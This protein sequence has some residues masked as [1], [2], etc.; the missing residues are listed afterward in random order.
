MILSKTPLRISLVGGSSDLQA[1]LD[2]Y[3]RGSVISF[4]SSLYTYITLKERKGTYK[5]TYSHTEEVVN[6]KD[7]KNDIAREVIQQFDLPPCEIGFNCD[8]PSTGSGLASSSSYL[9]S[10]LHAASFYWK[11]KLTQFDL[12][13]MALQIERKFNPLTGHQDPYGCGLGSLKRLNFYKNGDVE[14]KYL[15]ES[16]LNGMYMYL[17]PTN[18]SRSSTDVL[19]TIDIDKCV[20]LIDSVNELESLIDS[21]SDIHNIMNKSWKL[22]KKTSPHIM[23]DECQLIEESIWEDEAALSL[24]LCGA[25]GGGY[26]LVLCNKK[27]CNF[28]NIGY[29][30]EIDDKGT[31]V[32]YV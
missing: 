26:F 10:L 11:S 19:N 17:I 16:A 14:I 5:V 8:I 25:G 4:P 15:N 3:E 30:I 9:I 21:P 24:K 23:T 29:N 32:T 2:K 1:Y 6:F 28:E 7:I 13:K 12:C 31:I 18:K 27:S 20:T 22:K